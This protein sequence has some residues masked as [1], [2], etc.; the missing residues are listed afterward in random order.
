MATKE[1]QGY[2]RQG[3]CRDPDSVQRYTHPSIE[4][5]PRAIPPSTCLHLRVFLDP[6]QAVNMARTTNLPLVSKPVIII[7]Q[8][9]FENIFAE[10]FEFEAKIF[11]HDMGVVLY[12]I[13]YKLLRL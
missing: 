6:N 8:P 4:Q 2:G 12:T 13:P 10:G 11:T 3:A 9:R 1:R 5:T 7:L